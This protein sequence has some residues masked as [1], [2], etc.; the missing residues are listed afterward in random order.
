ML[1]PVDT[2]PTEIKWIS[3]VFVHFHR[4]QSYLLDH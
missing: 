3:V 4:I 1:I 2:W